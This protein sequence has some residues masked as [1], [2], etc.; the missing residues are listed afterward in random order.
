MLYASLTSAVH[1]VCVIICTTVERGRR[2]IIQDS[3]SSNGK[4]TLSISSVE[5]RTNNNSEITS[6]KQNG[7]IMPCNAIKYSQFNYSQH[8]LDG[9]D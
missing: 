4:R 3:G 8:S 2:K 1:D 6:V 7:Y 5:S 9:T